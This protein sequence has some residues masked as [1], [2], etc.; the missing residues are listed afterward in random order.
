MINLGIHHFFFNPNEDMPSSTDYLD[1][2][3][4]IQNLKALILKTLKSSK[5]NVDDYID[6]LLTVIL[7]DPNLMNK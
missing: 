3:I 2:S 1:G 6:D 7:D 5:S 4:E